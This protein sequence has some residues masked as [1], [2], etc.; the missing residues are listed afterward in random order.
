MADIHISSNEWLLQEDSF[1]E[2]VALPLK[3]S[4]ITAEF[5]TALNLAVEF[6]ERIFIDKVIERRELYISNPSEVKNIINAIWVAHFGEE[7]YEG[8]IDPTVVL[9]W[10]E[11]TGV[12]PVMSLDIAVQ[13]LLQWA[14]DKGCPEVIVEPVRRS[15]EKYA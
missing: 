4:T 10:G 15:L 7:A 9:H 5:N 8:Y 11:R 1:D 3:L 6:E 12:E 2:D 13:P 14:K